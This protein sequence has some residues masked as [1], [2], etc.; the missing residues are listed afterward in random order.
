MGWGGFRGGAGGWSGAN[1]RGVDEGAGDWVVVHVVEFFDGF[2]VGKDVEVV[3]A[4]LPEGTWGEALGGGEF[5]GLD[6]FRE[7]FGGGFGERRRWTCS[8]MTT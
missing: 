1:L 3:V 6:G 4:G 7:G 8:G 5:E 2:A